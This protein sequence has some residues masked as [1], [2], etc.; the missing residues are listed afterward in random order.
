MGYDDWQRVVDVSG[1]EAVDGDVVFSGPDLDGEVLVGPLEDLVGTVVRGLEWGL[2]EFP[3]HEDELG[4]AQAAR[5]A[6]LDSAMGAGRYWSEVADSF[7]E[8]SKVLA[9]RCLWSILDEVAGDRQRRTVY[10]FGWRRV[11]V[12]L[13]GSP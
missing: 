9:D 6:V 1:L 7:T 13:W 3:L 11:E 4:L 5:Y 12:F 8:L 2:F 10:Q